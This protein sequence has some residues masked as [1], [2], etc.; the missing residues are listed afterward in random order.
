[1]GSTETLGLTPHRSPRVPRA[2]PAAGSSGTR[3]RVSAGPPSPRRDA[4]LRRQPRRR[5]GRAR[6]GYKEALPALT[7]VGGGRGRAP[8]C[9]L[10]FV[11]FVLLPHGGGA[12][13]P[14][15][16]AGTGGPSRPPRRKIRVRGRPCLAQRALYKRW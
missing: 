5:K 13:G 1:M 8:F 10:G 12:A 7:A 4:G 9:L 11:L 6:P 2:A 3:S 16:S 14:A 15:G